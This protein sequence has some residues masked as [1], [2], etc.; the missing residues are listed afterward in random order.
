LLENLVR[1]DPALGVLRTNTQDR[2]DFTALY[3]A[4]LCVM[5]A[6]SQNAPDLDVCDEAIAAL[7]D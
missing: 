4:S 2:D 3:T 7:D 6:P 1:L 5:Q